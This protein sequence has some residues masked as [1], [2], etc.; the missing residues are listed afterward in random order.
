METAD[1]ESP[2]KPYNYFDI[3]RGT[4]IGGLVN[5]IVNVAEFRADK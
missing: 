5:G 3:I 2:P 1:L 4:S